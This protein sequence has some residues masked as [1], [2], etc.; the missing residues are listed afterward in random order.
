MQK[1]ALEEI[2]DNLI[3][4]NYNFSIMVKILNL[5]TSHSD[6]QFVISTEVIVKD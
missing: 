2:E 5:V 6:F 4:Y 1:M 3:T